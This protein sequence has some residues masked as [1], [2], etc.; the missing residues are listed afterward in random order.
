LHVSWGK[1]SRYKFVSAGE[2]HNWS[3]PLI[4]AIFA[5]TYK[6]DPEIK[7]N[8]HTVL[9]FGHAEN[10]VNEMPSVNEQIHELWTERA[11][12]RDKLYV[13]VYPMPGSTQGQRANIQWQLVSEYSPAGNY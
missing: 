4:P 3:P 2:L 13:F 6:K 11:G 8:A 12:N 9:Y 5:I 1:N 7:P 10:L